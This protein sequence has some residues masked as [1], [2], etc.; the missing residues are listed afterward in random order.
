MLESG[1]VTIRRQFLALATLVACGLPI[2]CGDSTTDL[3]PVKGIV[4]LDGKPLTSGRVSAVPA[5]GR[6]ANGVIGADGTFE[7]TTENPGDGAAV[8]THTVSVVSMSPGS[9]GPEGPRGK[10]LVPEKYTN[11]LTSGLTIEVKPGE[12][13]VKLELTSE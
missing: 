3:A 1:D 9:G 12:N 4:L 10:L 11:D 6:G 2:G 5:K 7:L 13:N 8:G